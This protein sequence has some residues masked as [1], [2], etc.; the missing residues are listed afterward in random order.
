MK[1]PCV[2]Y[3]PHALDQRRAMDVDLRIE[4]RK[5]CRLLY[6]ELSNGTGPATTGELQRDFCGCVLT[7]RRPEPGDWTSC[8]G[9]K[10][11]LWVEY[12]ERIV[13]AAA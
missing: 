1:E 12:I 13:Q 11:A 3:S 9:R 5:V 8:C 10:I 4:L 7:Y 2:G 6:D